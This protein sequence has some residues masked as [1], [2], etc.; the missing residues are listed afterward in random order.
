MRLRLVTVAACALASATALASGMARR[1]ALTSSATLANELARFG[2][3]LQEN[4]YATGPYFQGFIA[5][6]NEAVGS[7]NELGQDFSDQASDVDL[8]DEY[9]SLEDHGVL[10]RWESA[11]QQGAPTFQREADN[12]RNPSDVRAKW[13]ELLIQGQKVRDVRRDLRTTLTNWHS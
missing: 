7:M 6:T 4:P 3:D 11:Y 13:R 9:V 2:E 10:S 8:R 1:T 12:A 5:T